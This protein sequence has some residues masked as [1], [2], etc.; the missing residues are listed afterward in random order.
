MDRSY[1][2]AALRA[3]VIADAGNRCG[4]CHSAE[5]LTGAPLEFDHIVP[6]AAGGSNTRENLWRICH[7]C[8][9]YK[10]AQTHAKDD[11][12]GEFV[13]IFVTIQAELN[14]RKIKQKAN[15]NPIGFG[16]TKAI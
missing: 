3:G 6:L 8:N 12:S 13:R 14:A 1:L 4:Y 16:E 5:V 7:R 15:V 9:Q 10:G 2:S 11:S